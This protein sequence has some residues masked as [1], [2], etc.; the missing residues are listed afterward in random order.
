MVNLRED[1]AVALADHRDGLVVGELVDAV[2]EVAHPYA[3]ELEAAAEEGGGGEAEEAVE[4][5]V[6]VVVV[7]VVAAVAAR[8]LGGEVERGH[9]EAQVLQDRADVAVALQDF[10]L[11]RGEV[12]VD[13]S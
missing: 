12:R 9:A 4:V 11:V 7:V 13:E 6:V 1:V 2:V 10:L 5:V 3:V 8:H